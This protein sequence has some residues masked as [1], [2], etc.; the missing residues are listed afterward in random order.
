[1]NQQQNAWIAAVTPKVA[2]VEAEAAP[3]S[4][5]QLTGAALPQG[6]IP[7]PDAADRLPRWQVLGTAAL[8]IIGSHGGAGES[9]IS[10]LIE[11]SRP[12]HHSWPVTGGTDTNPRV[13][14]V[15]RS[16]MN[17][18]EAAQRALIEWTSTARPQVDLLG[19]VILADAP[20]K[21]P[22]PLRDLAAIVGGG[23]PR[24]WHL[25]WVEAW[26]TG[27]LALG[28][29]PR[30]IRKFITEVNSLLP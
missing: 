26:R 16:S 6:G 17:G 7:A 15:C 8:W 5:P 27:D 22:K 28:Q 24:L 29:S 11:G 18:L 21:L 3:V 14:L 12:T 2:P 1:M 23:A 9:T 19:L 25:P 4:L 30:E 10:R 13:L 20:G